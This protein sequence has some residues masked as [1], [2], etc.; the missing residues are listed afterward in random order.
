M[1]GHKVSYDPGEPPESNEWEEDFCARPACR[2]PYGPDLLYQLAGPVSVGNPWPFCSAECK[3][4]TEDEE[5]RAEADYAAELEEQNGFNLF[6]E[7][8]VVVF[9]RLYL[10]AVIAR[11]G[12]RVSALLKEIEEVKAVGQAAYEALRGLRGSDDAQG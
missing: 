4:L 3:H 2:K 11:T 10:E 1:L 12:N 8:P 7:P 9:D 6:D 5:A